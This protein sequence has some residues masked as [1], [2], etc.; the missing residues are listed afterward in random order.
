LIKEKTK[1]GGR[2]WREKEMISDIGKGH[3]TE[4]QE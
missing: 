4:T 2:I 1:T 3:K